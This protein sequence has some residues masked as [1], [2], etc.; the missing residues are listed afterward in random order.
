MSICPEYWAWLDKWDLDIS[1]RVVWEFING[2][3]D[4][5][6]TP[7]HQESVFGFSLINMQD[8]VFFMTSAYNTG[9]VIDLQTVILWVEHSFK[10]GVWGIYFVICGCVR[11][12]VLAWKE[13]GYNM[14][15]FHQHI[16]SPDIKTTNYASLSVPCASFN[17]VSL[18][19][20]YSQIH[21]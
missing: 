7:I 6:F 16:A 5:V 17:L 13:N 2:S 10:L 12:C 1:A 8:K 15:L 21:L 19:Y 11:V 3:F 4:I 14:N 20:S 18:P 9:W